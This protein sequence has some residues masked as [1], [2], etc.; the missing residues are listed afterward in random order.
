MTVRGIID[1]FT[2]WLNGEGEGREWTTCNDC[3][4]SGYYLTADH[5]TE[6]PV[7]TPGRYDGDP[8]EEDG[9]YNV[10]SHWCR[11]C[12]GMGRYYYNDDGLLIPGRGDEFDQPDTG[13]VDYKDY[14]QSREWRDRA[15]IVKAHSAWRCRICNRHE[16]EVTLDAHHNTY[17]RLGHERLSD[18]ICLCRDCHKI[19]DA[20]RASRERREKRER[21]FETY[22][23]KRW[24]QDWPDLVDED[25]AYSQFEEWLERKGVQL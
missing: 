5:E 9:Y 6:G 2:A 18:L 20:Q 15:N 22:A 25:E 3:N 10:R 21:A 23:E 11:T 7:E 24:G 8:T 19:A 14:M 17:E 1:N 16:S 12:R 4:G 13:K